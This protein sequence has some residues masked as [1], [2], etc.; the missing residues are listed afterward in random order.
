VYGHNPR[1]KPVLMD[2]LK[3]IDYNR[4]L[5]IAKER[6]ANASAWTFMFIGDF[7]EA[8]LRPLI[9]QYLAAL[10]DKGK[11]EKGHLTS[12]FQKGVI[13]NTFRRKMEMPKALAYMF[14]H[15][16]DIPYSV[17]NAIKANMIGQILS[18]VYLKKIREEASAAYSCGAEGGATIEGDYHDYT[19]LATCPMKPEKADMAL[20]IMKEEAENMTRTCDPAMLAKVKEYMLKSYDNALKTNGYWSGVINMYRKNGIDAHTNYRELIKGQT[21]QGLCDF[22]KQILKSGNRI[23]VVMLPQE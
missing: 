17:D 22:M 19:L 21:E 8:K 2:D 15:T 9:C 7:D 14:W 4:I 6:T 10:P 16:N 20:S 3:D 23:S 13:D 5:E 12:S 11:V 18:M 1:L